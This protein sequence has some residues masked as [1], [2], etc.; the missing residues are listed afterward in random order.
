VYPSDFAVEGVVFESGTMSVNG[1]ADFL[2]VPHLALK[3]QLALENLDLGYFKPM[4]SRHNIALRQGAL[5]GVGE[6]EYTPTMKV[7]HLQSAT[8]ERVQMDFIH[9]AEAAGAR[10]QT[11]QK[12]KGKAREV[13]NVPD[14][15]IRADQVRL[16][17]SHFGFVNKAAQPTYRLFLDAVNADLTNFSNQL[18]GGV[19]AARITG[20]FM[21]S[22]R[23]VVAATFRP[24]TKGPN[25]GLAASI[26]NTQMQTMNDLLRAHGK[27][28]VVQGFFSLY[29]ELRVQNG[30]V[31]GYVKPLFREMD[32]YDAQQDR[33]KGLFQQLYE[34][35]A[36][37]VSSLLENIPRDEV[38]TTAEISGPL[39]DPQASTWQ[40]LMQLVQNAFF[41]AILP[42]FEG[43]LRRSDR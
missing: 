20:A 32:I 15:L 10:R 35:V 18:T 31:R 4:A 3:A 38:A 29:T 21:G 12:V 7:V 16:V 6:I 37:G 42:G 2:A 1:Q 30:A 17:K 28:D 19:A 33:G 26:E 41:R 9:T 34:A 13:S 25:F 11:V 14:I 43:E 40:V 24:E 39:D 36:G 23:T 8:L 27:I 22:G 5:S